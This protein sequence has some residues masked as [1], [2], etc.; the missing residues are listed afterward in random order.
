MSTPYTNILND[1]KTN[2]GITG[3][4]QDNTIQGW[5]DEIKQFLL[6][7]GIAESIVNS[8]KAKGVISRGV[9]DLWNYGTGDG[10]LSPY[11]YQRATQLSYVDAEETPEVISE[12]TERITSLETKV[13]EHDKILEDVLVIEGGLNE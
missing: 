4:F 9:S 1:V 10:K 2:L 12:L 7:G 3:E 8:I 13:E 11:F 5:I 6:D